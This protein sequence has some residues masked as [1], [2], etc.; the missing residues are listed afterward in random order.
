MFLQDQHITAVIM[1]GR[2]RFQNG[3]LIQ[4]KE[5]FDPAVGAKLAE[6][7]NAIWWAITLSTSVVNLLK[8]TFELFSLSALDQAYRRKNQ[9]ICSLS[10]SNL[11][12]SETHYKSSPEP[13]LICPRW[14][15]LRIPTNLSS[16]H[17]REHLAAKSV[18]RH[19]LKKS[20]LYI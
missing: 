10:F 20:M 19:M 15:L 1:F 8:S 18:L 4:P 17:R 3:V 7:R 13:F 14:S 11:Q 6:F 9:R 12:R 16:S 5:P 2:G